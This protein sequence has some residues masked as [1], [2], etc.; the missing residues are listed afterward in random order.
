MA[1]TVAHCIPLAF[2]T[3]VMLSWEEWD[4]TVEVGGRDP[5]PL[6]GVMARHGRKSNNLG[7]GKR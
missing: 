6:S 1:S 7:R 2:G 5:N 3:L 4:V